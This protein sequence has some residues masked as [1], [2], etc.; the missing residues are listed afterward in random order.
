[1]NRSPFNFKVSHFRENRDFYI[2]TAVSDRV[3]SE[4]VV[5]NQLPNY[6]E[7]LHREMTDELET[8]L[9]PMMAR[10]CRD[11]MSRLPRIQANADFIS[12]ERTASPVPIPPTEE[13]QSSPLPERPSTFSA[14]GLPYPVKIDIEQYRKDPAILPGQLLST[15]VHSE[16]R[17]LLFLIRNDK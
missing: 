1:M 3:F 9:L 13:E 8:H 17:A 6:E 7:I 16:S 10:T 5:R 15:R 2:L 14:Y 12:F 11:Y 4:N